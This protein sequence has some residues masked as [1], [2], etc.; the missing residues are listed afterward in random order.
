MA[1][2]FSGRYYALLLLELG[3]VHPGLAAS[4]YRLSFGVKNK[5]ENF[6]VGVI[7]YWVLH[8]KCG[9]FELL[10]IAILLSQSL[11]LLP[12]VLCRDS[13]YL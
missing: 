7:S 9:Y 13:L 11:T 8:M 3:Y 12:F 1:F 6:G 10:H 5:M 4:H 2:S